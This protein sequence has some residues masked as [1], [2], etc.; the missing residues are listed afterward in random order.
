MA[1][2]TEVAESASTLL[3]SLGK[4]TANHIELFGPVPGAGWRRGLPALFLIGSTPEMSSGDRSSSP[5]PTLYD[6]PSGDEDP[7][8]EHGSEVEL[9]LDLPRNLAEQLSEVA[10]HLGLSPAIVASRAVQMICN[11]IGLTQDEDLSSTTL[12]Q[13]Y[14][15]RLDLLHA[16]D[17][18]LDPESNADDGEVETTPSEATVDDDYDWQDVDNIIGRVV[19]S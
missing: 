9:D 1:G 8:P 7:V 19:S 17:Y 11:E 12:I 10:S 15:T 3:D 14:Q 16:L 6:P 2:W 4:A 18:D 5:K 13:K